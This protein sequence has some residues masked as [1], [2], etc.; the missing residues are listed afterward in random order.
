ML[1][2]KYYWKM[3][4]C[5]YIETGIYFLLKSQI[6]I[7]HKAFFKMLISFHKSLRNLSVS[8]LIVWLQIATWWL[9]EALSVLHQLTFTSISCVC[10]STI[11]FLELT[12]PRYLWKI[13]SLFLYTHIHLLDQSIFRIMPHWSH[14]LGDYKL[15]YSLFTLGGMRQS[16]QKLD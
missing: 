6:F 2:K 14:I 16:K 8:I 7:E 10:R 4:S 9:S 12:S 3:S 13:S 1:I 11:T 15:H 5:F